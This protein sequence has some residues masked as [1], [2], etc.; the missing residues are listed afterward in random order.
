MSKVTKYKIIED[1]IIDKINKGDYRVGEQ[2]PTEN[3]LSEQFNIGRLTV[4]KALINLSNEGY[5]KRIAG[6]GSFVQSKALVKNIASKR[7]SFTNDM[8]TLGMKAGAKLIKYELIKAK[9]VPEIRD[10]LELDDDDLIHYFIRLRTGDDEPI[11]ISYTYLS[12]KIIPALDVNCLSKSLKEYLNSIGVQTT[13]VFYKMSATLPT[14]EQKELLNVSNIALFKNTH[15][16]YTDERL[17]YEYIETYYLGNKYEY[18]I[19]T[20]NI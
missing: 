14:Q 9:D 7:S 19:K 6:K 10:C 13:G 2:I 20:G 17:P 1:Y 12:A 15:I 4:N 5:I 3:Q 18:V 8:E 16:T 11:A